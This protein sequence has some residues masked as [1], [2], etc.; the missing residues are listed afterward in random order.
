MAKTDETP[1][2]FQRPHYGIAETATQVLSGINYFSVVCPN[3][4]SSVN[5]VQFRLTSIIDRMIT[6]LA[7]PTPGAIYTSGVYGTLQP[8]ASSGTWPNPPINFPNNVTDNLQW[9]GFF[10][11]MYGYY[12]VLGVEWELTV[13]NPQTNFNAD[14]VVG[15][16]IDTFGVNNSTQVHPTNATLNEMEFWPDVTWVRAKSSGD[17]AFDN[18][19]VIK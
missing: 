19:K 5:N 18:T 9:R 7:T 16:T 1:I 15:W 11:K 10:T 2:T 12:R 3:N 17:A 14:Q 6:T 4:H 13:Q 8:Y